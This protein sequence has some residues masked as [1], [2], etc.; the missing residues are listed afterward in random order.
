MESSTEKKILQQLAA[1]QR[2]QDEIVAKLALLTNPVTSLDTAGKAKLIR[3]AQ[4]SG[5]RKRLRKP[6]S[7]SIREGGKDENSRLIGRYRS[8]SETNFRFFERQK[9][10]RKIH[11]LLGR[12]P[13]V[14]RA[15]A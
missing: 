8:D 7:L 1:I 15:H 6:L 4:A 3:E 9:N 13:G 2:R 10:R 5:D 14:R 12:I 11:S